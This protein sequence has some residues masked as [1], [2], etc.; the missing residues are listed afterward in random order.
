MKDKIDY[1]PLK[2]LIGVWVG[3]KGLDVSPEP[4]GS[5]DSAYDETMTFEAIGDVS[6]AGSQTLAV[7]YYRQIVQRS[8]DNAVF[9]DET[10]YWMWDAKQKIVMH[11]LTIPRGVS[12]L[13]GGSFDGSTSDDG[14]VILKVSA[15]LEDDNWKIIQSPFM[16][17]NASTKK[18]DQTFIIDNGRLSYSQTMLL[19]I[20][21]KTF[22][23]TDHNDLYRR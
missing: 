7:L 11:S 22:E 13:A 15:G 10:G 23:H 3:D 18:F 6:N 19:D 9:H 20:Y 4:D 8:S 2:E 14:R 21:G 5:E 17:K 1:G 16:E 12:V